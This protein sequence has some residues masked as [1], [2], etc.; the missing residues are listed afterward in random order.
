[1]DYQEM[2]FNFFFVKKISKHMFPH[3]HE[4]YDNIRIERLFKCKHLG[5]WRE[6]TSTCNAFYK[7]WILCTIANTTSPLWHKHLYFIQNILCNTIYLL[8]CVELFLVDGRPHIP[9]ALAIPFGMR[10]SKQG[11]HHHFLLKKLWTPF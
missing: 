3:K 10:T 7:H 1:M 2:K 6:V 8:R 4:K 9:C 5:Q 11:R